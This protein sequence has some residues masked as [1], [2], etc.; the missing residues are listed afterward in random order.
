MNLRARLRARETPES[1]RETLIFVALSLLAFIPYAN[2]LRGSFVYDDY[3]QVVENPY[4]HS[5]RYLREIFTTTV[6][7][8][9]GAQ[10]V[11]NYYRP[12]M[13]FGYLLAY[14]IAGAIPFSFHLANIVLNV[15]VVLL[16]FSLVR[17][18]S[19]ERIALVAAGL[20]AL[21]PLHTESVAWVAGVT[22]LEL[23][24]FYLLTFI[25]Y[26]RLPEPGKAG[27]WRAAMCASFILAL[28]SKEQAMTL[29]VLLTIY[30]FFY[31][32]D[33]ATTSPKEKLSRCG[34]LWIIAAVYLVARGI[35]LGGVAS[36]VSRPGLSRYEVVLSAISLLGK[37][38]WKLVWPGH[39]SAYYV[40]HKSSH[41]T[42]RNVLLGLA[43]LVLCA[44]LFAMLWRG[45]H[46]LSFAFVMIFLPLGPVLNAQWMPASVFAERY[47]YLPSIGFSW[48]A[49]WAAVKLWSAD[50]S[51]FVRPLAR[52]VPLL[53]IALA[54]A[55]AVKTVRRNR[56]WRTEEALFLRTLEQGDASLIR[57][58]LGALYFNSG[59]LTGAEHEWL[60]SLAAGPN[61]A[62]A[63]DNLALLRQR[64]SRYSESLDYSWRALRARPNYMMGHLNLAQTLELMDRAAE[65]DWQYRIATAISPLSTRAHNTYGE[66]LFNSERLDDARIEF[67]HSV[68]VDPT[69]D[70]YDRL[71]DIYLT[72]PDRK[73]AEQ[74]YRGAL[75]MNIFDSHAHFALG[76][77]L[78]EDGH[79]G[80]ALREIESG[81]QTDPNDAAAKLALVRLRGNS[82]APAIPH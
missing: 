17:R 31:R 26:L 62:F 42:D 32:E 6:W 25:F 79:P 65:A 60:E 18:L 34:P 66:F 72:V 8:F 23:A 61:N 58:N 76:Q 14:Q 12:L 46:L 80:D 28:L 75:T 20:F 29:P 35:M 70:A 67:E 71:G 74:A 47:L 13:T 21:H 16:V 51:V 82:P 41:I 43:G 64:Q 45:A 36:I 9:Q 38:M 49:A 68:S 27:R 77:I 15:V 11:T 69:L 10:G 78:E 55:F 39:L 2:T 63:L 50:S 24:V 53:L 3:F 81:L 48:L 30:E 59:N 40:F 22:D 19:G 52:A 33:R 1:R 73:K 54:L 37:Y 7:S 57:T 4:V 44:I 5:F 56:D